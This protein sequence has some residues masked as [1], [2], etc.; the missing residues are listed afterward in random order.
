M[1]TVKHP[2]SVMAW[3]CFSGKHG[4]G[5][6][7]FLP[8]N[9]TMNSD[10]YIEILESKILFRY[11]NRN[12][13]FFMQ[14]GAPCHTSKKSMKWLKRAGVRVMEWP[15]N[16]PDLNPI[17]NLWHI[18]KNKLQDKQMKNLDE[19]KAAIMGVWVNEVSPEYCRALARSMVS[20]CQAVINADGAATKY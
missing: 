10:R 5:G 20:R 8:K 13:S 12:C 7:E 4:R 6:L 19:L 9:V 11:Q 14:D 2:A 16:S 15:G 18:M 17:E 1:T 3:G